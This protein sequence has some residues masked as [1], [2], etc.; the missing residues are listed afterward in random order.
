MAILLL[1]FPISVEL[2]ADGNFGYGVDYAYA[3]K[4]RG[5]GGD[6][7]DNS[8]SGSGNDDDDND[9]RDRDRRG[10]EQREGTLADLHL[11]YANG[12]DERILNG[13]YRL[14]D[15]QGRTVA[16]RRATHEDLA[17]MRALVGQ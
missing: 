1:P 14:V 15:P 4:G 2:T 11:R 17:R 7:D 3:E 10:S 5:R 8:G 13:R 6:D 9:G 16:N 12:W